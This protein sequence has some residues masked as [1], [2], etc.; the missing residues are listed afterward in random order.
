LDEKHP[1]LATAYNNVAHL[2]KDLKECKKA[3]EYMKKAK[4]I[5]S[6]YE[7]KKSELHDSIQFIK[8]IEHNI[9]KEEKLNYQ[10][11][12]KFCKE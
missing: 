8:E 1:Y 2:Y 7:Y 9:K 12:G 3:K 10:K 6:L 4:N 5:F 11:R